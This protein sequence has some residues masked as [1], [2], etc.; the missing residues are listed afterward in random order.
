MSLPQKLRELFAAPEALASGAEAER[1][2]GTA[3]RDLQLKF[4]RNFLSLGQL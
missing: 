4:A 1:T 2:A 3:Y